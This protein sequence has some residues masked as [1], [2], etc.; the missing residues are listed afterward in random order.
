MNILDFSALGVNLEHMVWVKS[1]MLGIVHVSVI[2]FSVTKWV[3]TDST[4]SGG[5][6]GSLMYTTIEKK[7]RNSKYRLSL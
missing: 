5:P 4:A 3:S 6:K 2:A 1:F 7:E